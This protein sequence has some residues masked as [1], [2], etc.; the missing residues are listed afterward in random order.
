MHLEISRVKSNSVTPIDF[1]VL[2]WSFQLKG[3]IENERACGHSLTKRAGQLKSFAKPYPNVRAVANFTNISRAAF[4]PNSF[5]KNSQS[6]TSIKGHSNNIWHSK[7]GGGSQQC[8]QITHGR[9][10]GSTNVS[11]KLF[12]PFWTII[13]H[14]MLFLAKKKRG[15]WG[16]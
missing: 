7:G 15:K 4:A 12:C 2:G 16:K 5:D 14:F 10:R 13:S 6:Q 9:G 8:H 1:N 11:W 3:P